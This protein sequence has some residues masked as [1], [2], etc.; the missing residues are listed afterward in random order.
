L[1]SGNASS[2]FGTEID[3]TVGYVYNKNLNLQLVASLFSP[4]EIFK[5]TKGEECSTWVYL[6]AVFNM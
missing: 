6:M 1:A 4:G 5:E 2:D 3:L